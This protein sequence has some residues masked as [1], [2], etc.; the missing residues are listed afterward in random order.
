MIG[1]AGRSK[2]SRR[3]TKIR[4]KQLHFD[5]VILGLIA[6]PL[7]WPHPTHGGLLPPLQN[8]NIAYNSPP[9]IKID[10]KVW[11][12]VPI[13]ENINDV[14]FRREL[15]C[16]WRSEEKIEREKNANSVSFVHSSLGFRSN[17]NWKAGERRGWCW[18]Y[19]LWFWNFA[20]ITPKTL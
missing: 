8:I 3:R 18:W 19:R 14:K 20:E 12:N 13:L 10:K 7:N 4:S 2:I 16:I 9:Q 15:V 11:V 6:P 5:S 17:A 1:R